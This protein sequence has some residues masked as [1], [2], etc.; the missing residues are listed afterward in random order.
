[1][2]ELVSEHS[3]TYSPAVVKTLPKPTRAPA[4][5]PEARRAALVDAAVPLVLERGFD[6]TTKDLA[7]A[8]GVAEGTIFRVFESK[9]DL[10]LARADHLD[11]LAAISLEWPLEAR[12]AAAVRIWQTVA[13]RM[14]S[15]FVA[16][17]GAGDHQRLGN[18]HDLVDPTI[19]A[20]AE[21]IIAALLAPEADRLRR[22]I[23]DI[24]RIMGSLVLASVHPVD[25]LSPA[26]TPED[27][28]DLL[29]HGVLADAPTP[30]VSDP[31]ETP[32]T[33]PLREGPAS[34][35]AHAAYL[36]R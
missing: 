8:A 10:V 1:M 19:V 31:D 34:C 18:P 3:L 4:L 11:E 5:A 33:V 24:V 28:V 26:S 25:A 32:L 35:S 7:A 2:N 14:V 23:P 30:H 36:D 9:D 20:R 27:L 12:L 17:H 22:P 15:V 21:A 29:L 13:R 6:V 16:F